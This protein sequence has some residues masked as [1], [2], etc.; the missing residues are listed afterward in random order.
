MMSGEPRVQYFETA[1]DH[2]TI[3]YN[4]RFSWVSRGW[5]LARAFFGPDGECRLLCQLP[6]DC[7]LI[8]LDVQSSPYT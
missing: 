8:T 2:E 6:D 5:L 1:R 7:L 4:E 3:D